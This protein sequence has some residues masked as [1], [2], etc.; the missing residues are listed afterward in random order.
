M[1]EMNEGEIAAIRRIRHEI[2]EE[3]GH[4]VHRVAAF[5][6]TVQDE[7][8]ESGEFRF[9]ESRPPERFGEGLKRVN[10]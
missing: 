1:S 3:C 5:Y 4:D 8:M 7:L 9:A 6:R 10:T 2:S